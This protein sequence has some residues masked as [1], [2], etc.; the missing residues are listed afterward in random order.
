[1]TS[2]ARGKGSAAGTGP[3][4]EKYHLPIFEARDRCFALGPGAGRARKPGRPNWHKPWP[5]SLRGWGPITRE[6]IWQIQEE[7]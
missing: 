2:G 1:M 3:I 5:G 7:E 6:I 4:C